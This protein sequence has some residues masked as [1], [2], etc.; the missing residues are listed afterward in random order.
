VG[1][2]D[3]DPS[4]TNVRQIKRGIGEVD[5]RDYRFRLSAEVAVYMDEIDNFIV[6][7]GRLCSHRSMYV[8]DGTFNEVCAYLTGYA[9]ASPDCPLGGKGRIAFNSFVCATFRFPSK[10]AWPF[11]LKQ[12]SRDDNEAVTQL[13]DLLTDFAEKTK[14]KTHEEIVLAVMSRAS[15]HEEGEP[16]KVWRRFS[17]AIHRGKREEI[18]PLILDHRNADVLWSATYPD[19]I[20][21]LLDQIQE[22]YVV[23]VISGSD[24]DGEV[25]I[26]TP[27]FG[28]VKLKHLSGSWRVDASKI[29]DCWMTSRDES[30]QEPATDS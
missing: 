7:V 6:L 18:E 4:F 2:A 28:T 3:F 21:P 24:D 12:C 17:R 8:M 16:V 19:D 22:S 13:R 11:V 26:I 9:E 30:Q 23:S 29:I 10:Y 25:T 15:D 5:A 20:S 1:N 14:T 27:D